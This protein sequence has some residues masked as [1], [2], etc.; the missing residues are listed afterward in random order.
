MNKNSTIV[1]ILLGL[2]IPFVGYAIFLSI[3]DGIEEMGAIKMGAT[4]SS[5]R[6]RTSA[7]LGITLNLIP[8][9]IFN[10]RRWNQSMRGIVFP[11]FAYVIAWLFYFGKDLI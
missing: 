9:N 6:F 7:I 8:F 5:F 2:V 1:G 11:T 3:F 4:S 10:K